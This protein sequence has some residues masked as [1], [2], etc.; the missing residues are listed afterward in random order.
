MRRAGE[1]AGPPGERAVG[2]EGSRLAGWAA[3]GSWPKRE[4]GLFLFSI[5]YFLGA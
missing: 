4:G 3:P 2:G 5:P 1:P